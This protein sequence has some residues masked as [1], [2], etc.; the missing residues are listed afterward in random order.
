MQIRFNKEK[1]IMYVHKRNGPDRRIHMNIKEFQD[2]IEYVETF[3]AKSNTNNATK[4]EIDAFFDIC[5]NIN[6]L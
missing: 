3:S 5:H 1:T 6:D 4:D 2:L